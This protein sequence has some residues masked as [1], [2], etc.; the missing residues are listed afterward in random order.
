MFSKTTM[1][2]FSISWKTKIPLMHQVI[3][4]YVWTLLIIHKA[5]QKSLLL[6]QIIIQSIQGI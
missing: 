3:P 5:K 6:K 1:L 2:A 4:N